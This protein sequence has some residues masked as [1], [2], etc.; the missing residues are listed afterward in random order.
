MY[1]VDT[2]NFLPS[3]NAGPDTTLC[4]D[5]IYNMKGSGGITYTWHPATY[6]SSAT[7]PNAIAI[8]PNTEH[9]ELIV[10]NTYGCIDSAPVLLTVRPKL[11]VKAMVDN[12]T[13]CFGQPI[14]LSAKGAGGLP[15][16]YQYQW[17]NDSVSG[18]S[19]IKK[20]YQSGWHKVVLHDNCSAGSAT[21]SIYI[22]VAQIVKAEF[23]WTRNP[24]SI[25]KRPIHFINQSLNAISYLWVFRDHDSSEL[26]SPEHIY[27]DSGNYKVMLVAYG[28][29]NCTIDTAYAD[30]KIISNVVTIYIPDAFSPNGDGLNDFF[31][32]S[33]VGIQSYSYNIYNRWGEHLFE[34]GSGHTSWNGTFKGQPVIEGVY[35]YQLDVIDIEG[36]HHYLSGNITLMR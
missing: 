31:D 21:D 29:N 5:E 16:T 3:P 28:L 6:L 20:I 35:I 25:M 27:A 30:I 34:A 32:I 19:I 10:Q 4:Y 1:I 22:T 7:D 14:I 26:V 36:Q 9:Y 8:L 11:Q 24:N 18:D 33:G 23:S 2:V 15:S 13:I 17:V 12:A